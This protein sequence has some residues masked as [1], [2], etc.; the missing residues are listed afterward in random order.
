MTTMLKILVTALLSL[1]LV[2]CSDL[3]VKE[4]PVAPEVTVSWVTHKE[5][6]SSVTEYSQKSNGGTFT[7]ACT[8]DTCG[9]FIKPKSGCMYDVSYPVM[10]NSSKRIG[11]I[12]SKCTYLNRNGEQHQIVMFREQ[13]A[14]ILAL[15]EEMD[16]TM[17]FP[18]QGGDMDVLTISSLGMR[19]RLQEAA[20]DLLKS[21][22][23]K[24]TKNGRTPLG[25]RISQEF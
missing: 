11:V 5:E 17:S 22:K 13:T 18:T 14:F 9:V 23:Y 8:S 4:E 2:A 6:G 7:V 16:F 24:G 10:V 3:P 1:S 19:A 20:P 12:S 21:S 25:Q 15:L